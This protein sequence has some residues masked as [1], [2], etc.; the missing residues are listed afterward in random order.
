MPVRCPDLSLPILAVLVASAAVT[1]PAQDLAGTWFT[2]RGVLELEGKGDELTGR[3]GQGKTLQ[4]TRSGKELK[5]QAREGQAMLEAKWTLDKS[6]YRFDGE[7]TS[8]SG[9]GTWRGWRHD[10]ASEKGRS[11]NVAG[12]WRTSW[13]MLELEQSGNKVKGGLASQ[14]WTTVRG[15]LR[16]RSLQLDYESPTGNGTLLLDFEAGDKHALGHGTY[17]NGKSALLA[18]RLEGHTRGVAPKP[19]AIVNGIGKNRV[20]YWLRAPKAWKPGSKMPLLVFFHGSNYC[21]RPYV[22]SIAASPV[23][24]RFVVVGIDG[25][26]WNDDSDAKDPRQNYTYVNWMGKS[27]YQ[28]Y[29]NT[30]RESP[31][32][33]AE[34]MEELQ[35]QVGARYVLAG[36]HSQ[37]GFLTWFLAMH[38]PELVRGVFPMSSG[39]TMQCEPDVF[40]DAAL[41]AKQ[42]EVAIAVVHGRNDDVVAFTQGEGT[43]QSC[44]EHSFPA[45]R[46]F[47]NDAGHGFASLPWLAAV[48]WLELLAGD[49]VGALAKGAQA[50]FDDGRY[51]DAMA[52]VQRLRKLAPA[53]ATAKAIAAKVDDKAGADAQRFV[54]QLAAPGDGK[55]IDDF[56][57]FRDQFEFADCAAEAMKKFAALRGEHEA[58][59]KKLQGEA[60]GAFNQGDRDG[61]WKKYE[62]IVASWWASSWYPRV[63]RWLANRK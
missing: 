36:G 46:L 61:G 5:V 11:P 13:G 53:D 42:R 24:E 56:L 9:K 34:L 30:H 52:A 54:K 23:G 37:G 29:P 43:W 31:A 35:K 22:E 63:K 17:P 50:A 3:Y 32:L 59:A 33:V 8:G 27:T 2:S 20:V 25:E 28:G 49:D 12:H 47:A 39:M 48:E 60:R 15:E 10:P 21:S 58:P 45:L 62:E 1:L 57:A 44:A 16:G 6:G 7:W 4:A 40:A 19:G 41:K 26:S 51:R 55:W 14:G 18:Q 38:Y